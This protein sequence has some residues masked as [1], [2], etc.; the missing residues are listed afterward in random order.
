M[1]NKKN[2]DKDLVKR[3][4]VE[5]VIQGSSMEIDE[6]QLPYVE[7]EEP[8]VEVAKVEPVEEEESDEP[9]IDVGR[10]KWYAIRTFSGQERKIME[11]IIATVKRQGMEDRIFEVL[12]PTDNVIEMRD[13][14]KRSR[15]KVFFPGYV[16]VQMDLDKETRY[17]I[18][19][20]YGVLNFIGPGN[21]PQSLQEKEVKRVLGDSDESKHRNVMVAPFSVGDSIKVTDGPFNDF[22][23]YVQEIN[24]E[25]QKVK[26]MVSIFGRATPVELDFL[27]VQMEK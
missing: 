26:V 13:G 12:V 15:T 2:N 21:N 5:K 9:K 17:L 25:K 1:A 16:L 22:T 14:K 11:S 24:E 8:V 18:E 23:G 4:P 27:Q 3:D 6:E 7:E 20:A 19:D 10:A